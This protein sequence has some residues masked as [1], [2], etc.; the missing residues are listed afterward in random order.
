MEEG[1]DIT[2]IHNSRNSNVFLLFLY[3]AQKENKKSLFDVR[4]KAL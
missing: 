3:I 4:T 1:K 2:L